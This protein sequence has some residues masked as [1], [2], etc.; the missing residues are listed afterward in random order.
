MKFRLRSLLIA[1]ALIAHFCAKQSWTDRLCADG[2]IPL[3]TVIPFVIQTEFDDGEYSHR[4]TYVGALGHYKLVS[5]SAS[6][7]HYSGTRYCYVPKLYEIDGAQLDVMIRGNGT[8]FVHLSG[9]VQSESGLKSAIAVLNENDWAGATRAYIDVAVDGC[10][11]RRTFWYDIPKDRTN[12][13]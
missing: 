10:G 3:E 12:R 13:R 9:M 7:I 1:T 11:E 4:R 6:S 5:T 2:S 8:G